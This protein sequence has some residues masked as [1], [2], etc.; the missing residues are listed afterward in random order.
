MY[1]PWIKQEVLESGLLRFLLTRGGLHESSMRW[2]NSSRFCHVEN[3]QGVHALI[4]D[5]LMA[6][7]PL[8]NPESVA[9]G[10]NG[11]GESN[12]TAF[13]CCRPH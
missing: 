13:R 3:E 11:G 2:E 9:H 7:L 4:A 12:V 6:G 1:T 5:E 8:Q 10:G